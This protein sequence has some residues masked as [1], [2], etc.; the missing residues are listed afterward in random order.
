MSSTST[1]TAVKVGQY[2]LSKTLGIGSFGKVKRACAVLG[3]CCCW[4][5]RGCGRYT[6]Q[7]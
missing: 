2:R 4:G 1:T 3:T 7:R 6:E 5:L